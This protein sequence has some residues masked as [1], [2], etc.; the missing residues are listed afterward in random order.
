[1]G[2]RT[3]ADERLDSAHQ[4]IKEAIRDLSSIVIEECWGHDEFRED[5]TETIHEVMQELISLKK[6]LNR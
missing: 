6:K 4:H 2:V 1:M 3:A 5:Y